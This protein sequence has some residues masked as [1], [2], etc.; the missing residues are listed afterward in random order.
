MGLGS[1]FFKCLG[2]INGQCPW[3]QYISK[4]DFPFTKL[5]YSEDDASVCLEYTR[6]RVMALWVPCV[7]HSKGISYLAD[8]GQLRL[9]AEVD[10]Y[11]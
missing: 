9:C 11:K 10:I 1:L 5:Q 3:K 6:M 8:G 2:S 4:R 7:C